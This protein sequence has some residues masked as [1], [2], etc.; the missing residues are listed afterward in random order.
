M[1]DMTDL[2][3]DLVQLARLAV[4]ERTED[5]RLYV[6]R[7]VRKYRASDPELADQLNTYLRE[8]IPRSRGSPLRRASQTE[9][10]DETPPLADESRL[11]LLRT[12]DVG[13]V[14]DEPLLPIDLQDSLMQLI[15]E[16]RQ[17]DRLAFRGLSP[18]RS[19]VFIGPPGMGKTVTARWIAS[20]LDLPLYVLDLTA[21]MSSLLGRSGGNLRSALDFA[22]R[23]LSVL[24]L[25]EI[26]A[27]AKR[28]GGDSDV[29]ELKRLVT[30]ILQ[31][32]DDWPD[33]G[34][35]L[36]ATN[37]PKL[38]DP[39]LWRRFDMIVEFAMPSHVQMKEAIGRFL[40]PDAG[41]F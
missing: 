30:V 16:R 39:A 31:E 3:P 36:A 1:G 26:D 22:K 27:V 21:V 32:V 5:V 4:G 10:T 40:G 25:D 15:E 38:I 12:F 29:G 33:T 14:P 8:S 35:L 18:T 19:A 9:S 6:A 2:R 20:Q 13:L 7:L 24:L 11:A 17:V 37:H 41:A 34:L 28:R 23:T